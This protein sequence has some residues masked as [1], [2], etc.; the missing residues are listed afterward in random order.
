M[1]RIEGRDLKPLDEG[2]IR[3]ESDLEDLISRRPEILRE[4]L[5]IIG[6]Q[7]EVEELKDKIDLLAVDSNLNTVVIE[8]KKGQVKGGVDIQCLK[9]ASYVSNWNFDQL[10]EIAESYF[11]D[12]KIGKTF[13]NALQEFAG[14]EIDYEDVNRRQRIILVGTDFDP[15][16]MSVGKWLID[17]GVPMKFVKILILTDGNNTFLKSDVILEPAGPA[18]LPIAAKGRPWIEN[19][20]DWHLNQRCNRQT[21]EKLRELVEYLTSLEG[22]EVSWNQEL[23]V[24]F[25]LARYNWITVVTFPNQ[26]NIR[27]KVEAGYFNREEVSKELGI[28]EDKIEVEQLGRRD[29]SP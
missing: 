4:D 6:R 7:V 10:K 21:A 11:R 14:E 18:V 25:I 13:V 8:I 26:L 27:I 15:R 19:G 12:N 22:V 3:S 28:S 5:M 17:Q 16:I 20:Q 23:Y 2:S 1:W 29:E 24:A 9:Y